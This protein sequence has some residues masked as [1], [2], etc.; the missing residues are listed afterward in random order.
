MQHCTWSCSS[1]AT[2]LILS[3]P[4]NYRQ[5]ALTLGQL[6]DSRTLLSILQDH[7]HDA[8]W[9]RV[10][11]DAPSYVDLGAYMFQQSDEFRLAGNGQHR[12]VAT[13]VSSIYFVLYFSTF[14]YLIYLD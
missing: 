3:R 14:L 5:C 7:C 9:Y 11:K 2:D 1:F 4:F 12:N 13:T 8:L 6:C 10:P